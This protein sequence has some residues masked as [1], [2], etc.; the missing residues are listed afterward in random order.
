MFCNYIGLRTRLSAK[1][2]ANKEKVGGIL[3]FFYGT[4]SNE[5]KEGFVTCS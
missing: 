5:A 3:A 2:L 1:S 4:D